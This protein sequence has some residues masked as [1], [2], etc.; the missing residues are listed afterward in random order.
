MGFGL[1]AG[2]GGGFP[3]HGEAQGVWSR[4]PS[5]LLRHTEGPPPIGFW[6]KW[7]GLGQYTHAPC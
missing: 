4:P 2:P 7:V 3:L 6:T 1:P 5:L